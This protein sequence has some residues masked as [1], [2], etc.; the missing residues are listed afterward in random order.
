MKPSAVDV[1]CPTCKVKAGVPCKGDFPCR[2]RAMKVTTSV[3]G[4]RVYCPTC[5]A[6]QG[7]LCVGRERERT[8]YIHHAR[9]DE[10]FASRDRSGDIPGLISKDGRPVHKDWVIVDT[11]RRIDRLRVVGAVN[12]RSF[13]TVVAFYAASYDGGPWYLAVHRAKAVRAA[14]QHR[15]TIIERAAAIADP[16][17]VKVTYHVFGKAM[18][19]LEEKNELRGFLL[20]L[21]I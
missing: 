4:L 17:K 8:S 1:A 10:A 11:T 9:N 7:R 6:G 3:P 19:L 18:R 14:E 5:Q 12:V 2:R 16:K 21:G 15:P 20:G 13:Y